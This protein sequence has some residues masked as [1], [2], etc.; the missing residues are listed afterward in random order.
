M[1]IERRASLA[2]APAWAVQC[3]FGED[4]APHC[5]KAKEPLTLRIT[6]ASPR[7]MPKAAAGSIRASIHVTV[8]LV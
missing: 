3:V 8:S 1:M 7:L 6:W 5:G 4:D 2:E